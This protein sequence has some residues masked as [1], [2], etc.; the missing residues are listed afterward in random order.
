MTGVQTCALPIF[1]VLLLGAGGGAVWYATRASRDRDVVA[2]ADGGA[3]LVERERDGGVEL[4]ADATSDVPGPLPLSPDARVVVVV[5]P[6]SGD[7]GVLDP[8][9]TLP[10]HPEHP[11]NVTVE[12]LTRPAEANVFVGRTF[13]G[14]SGAR[15]TEPFGTT[16]SIECRLP[17]YVGKVKVVFDGTRDSVMC[18]AVRLKMCVD[19][20][21]NPYDDCE[22]KP[23]P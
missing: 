2:A 16:L 23:T 9:A 11:A 15:L 6:P 18:T 10:D 22:P 5:P 1:S 4:T 20:L 13:R 19:G 14:P 7:G 8:I 3:R 12:V 17:H 21:K